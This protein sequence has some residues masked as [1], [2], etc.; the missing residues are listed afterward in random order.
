[1]PNQQHVRMTSW[2]CVNSVAS[3]ARPQWRTSLRPWIE[4][5]SSSKSMDQS[6][7]ADYAQ[8]LYIWQG[9]CLT[10]QV[11][12]FTLLALIRSSSER[13]QNDQVHCCAIFV[14]CQ[15][16]STPVRLLLEHKS[17]S[18]SDERVTEI[19]VQISS[20]C[21]LSALALCLCLSQ[22]S[23]LHIRM[24]QETCC[25]TYDLSDRMYIHPTLFIN[26]S[27][28]SVSQDILVAIYQV[29]TKT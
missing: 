3:S 10:L 26:H 11:A 17:V 20:F 22:I 29:F 9:N 14:S 1:M 8:T 4:S 13:L 2:L 28:C 27:V 5:I 6:S 21:S 25:N 18:I 15:T 16:A 7:K 19:P 23:V 12:K 24:H